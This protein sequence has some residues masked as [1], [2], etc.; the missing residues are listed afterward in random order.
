[1][2]TTS[3]EVA[4][5]TA[6]VF[7]DERSRTPTPFE[8]TAR[9]LVGGRHRVR[10]VKAGTPC[11]SPVVYADGAKRGKRGVAHATALV[12]DFDH[13]STDAAEDV[14]RKL[15]AR[16]WAWLAYSSFS[17]HVGGADDVCFR[18]LV[19]VS[20]PITPAEYDAVWESAAQ[21]LGGYA[22]RNARDISRLWFVASCPAERAEHAW[23]RC[24]AGRPLDV[25]AAIAAH[26][27]KQRPAPEPAPSSDR[28]IARGHRNASLTSLAGAMRRQG[29][30]GPAMLEALLATNQSRCRPPLPDADVRRIVAS[31]Q[32]YDP[33]S[34][35]LLANPTDLGNAERFVAYA[36]ERFRYVPA[37]GT[38]LAFDGARW[39]RDVD[40]E[41]VRTARDLLRATAAQALA[42]SNQE[43]A[44]R[45][46]AH[47]LASESRARIASMLDLAQ[48]LLP[49]ATDALDQDH[50]AFNCANGT[51]DLRT[52]ALGPHD[53]DDL[54][55]RLS[56]VPWE[57][58]AACPRWEA[59]LDQITGGRK[60]VVAFLQRAIGYSLTGHVH[61]QVL[62]LLYGTGASG[63]GGP[64]HRSRWY[65]RHEHATTIRRLQHQPARREQ[66]RSTM[67]S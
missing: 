11:F 21:A 8:G 41:T 63:C 54:L 67:I 58:D 50:D 27:R 17:H 43:E 23:L 35:L 36:G 52:G 45:L 31:I 57:P 55:T 19:L 64:S 48:A 15:A 2:T 20:R 38:W 33:E 26:R 59:F 12:L 40:G 32:R 44:D 22:D 47:A 51:L 49:V 53:R 4:L 34:P 37:W 13:L 62:L 65:C 30:D 9:D 61:E 16:G 56:P 5:I 18:L 3:P 46:L 10:D 7:A 24:A 42:L 28:P 1:M 6:S 39:R 25:P 66:G 29:A 60:G 14:H